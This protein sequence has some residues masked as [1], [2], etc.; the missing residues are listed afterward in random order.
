MVK[1]IIEKI[2]QI[3]AQSQDI[4]KEAKKEAA[5]LVH[6]AKTKSTQLIEAAQ[7]RAAEEAQKLFSQAQEE[8]K[9]EIAALKKQTAE[10]AQQIK[11]KASKRIPEAKKLCR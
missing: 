2:A 5:L 11:A 7:E 3:E 8:A 6:N 1:E 4:R 9:K 10:E